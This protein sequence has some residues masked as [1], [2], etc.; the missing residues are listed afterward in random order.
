MND[1]WFAEAAKGAAESVE[2]QRAKAKA[3]VAEY[4]ARKSKELEDRILRMEDPLAGKRAAAAF[5]AVEDGTASALGTGIT[6]RL[7][8][9][10]SPLGMARGGIV[11]SAAA[12]ET[13]FPT[14][15]PLGAT[16]KSI[17]KTIQASIRRSEDPLKAAGEWITII[18]NAIT[19]VTRELEDKE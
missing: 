9:T 11:S 1:D 12:F 10:T 18:T 19:D 7:R 6:P 17:A 14:T 3:R 16:P 4:N 8:A 5:K 15:S 2:V 13:I